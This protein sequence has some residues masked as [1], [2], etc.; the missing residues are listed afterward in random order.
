MRIAAAAA[1]ISE[2]RFPHKEDFHCSFCSY[3][4]LCPA[5]EKRIPSATPA[6]SGPPN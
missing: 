1:A 2:K 5:K 3:R 6:K 4:S